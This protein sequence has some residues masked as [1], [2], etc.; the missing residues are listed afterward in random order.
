MATLDERID[1]RIAVQTQGTPAMDSGPG[2]P[3]RLFRQRTTLTPR[4]F[5][6]EGEYTIGEDAGENWAVWDKLKTAGVLRFTPKNESTAVAVRVLHQTAKMTVYQ[7]IA[8]IT[9]S[10]EEVPGIAVPAS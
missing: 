6:L 8:K 2:M 10:V 1:Y 3:A 4:K 9:W 5:A 7:G